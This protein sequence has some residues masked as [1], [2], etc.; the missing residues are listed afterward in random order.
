MT[1]ILYDLRV[2][3]DNINHYSAEF[4]A[5]N[6]LISQTLKLPQEP[7]SVDT[8]TAT[9]EI[10]LETLERSSKSDEINKHD[11]AKKH[12]RIYMDS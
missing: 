8:E 11:G 7:V 5:L 12:K 4:Q 2:I 3:G 9:M 10:D 1:K 6:N